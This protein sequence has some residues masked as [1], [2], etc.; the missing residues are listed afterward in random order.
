M[1][2][3]RDSS[4]VWIGTM[5]AAAMA[6]VVQVILARHLDLDSFGGINNTYAIASLIG[7]FG[8]Q[9]VGEVIMRHPRGVRRSLAIQAF[10]VLFTLASLLAVATVRIFE[11]A[12]V[13][14]TLMLAFIPFVVVHVGLLAGM[15]DAQIGHRT[16]GI[17]TW[18]TLLQAGRLVGLLVVIA[19]G[20][21]LF[22][23]RK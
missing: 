18:P 21:S 1:T 5:L 2:F 15:V 22:S 16:L 19:I 23:H 3:W 20:G 17:A 8:F 7:I 13:D 14:A 12:G 6:F 4:L 9:G 10:L 11:A